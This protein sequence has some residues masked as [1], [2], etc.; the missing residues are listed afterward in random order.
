MLQV[1]A[2]RYGQIEH[3]PIAGCHLGAFTTLVF[4]RLQAEVQISLRGHQF[5]P[6][7]DGEAV[8]DGHLGQPVAPFTGQLADELLAVGK[9]EATFVV[10]IF[11][12][13]MSAQ[14]AFGIA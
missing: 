7:A 14:K 6:V 5:Q 11:V 12:M 13:H 2:F 1:D 8:L 10:L 9:R 4:Q 3:M